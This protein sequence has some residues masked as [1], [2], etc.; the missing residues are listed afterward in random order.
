MSLSSHSF[1]WNT[2]QSFEGY[3]RV[4]T[5]VKPSFIL[6][7]IFNTGG[8]SGSQTSM[9]LTCVGND[10]KLNYGG[11]QVYK[12]G[13]KSDDPNFWTKVKVTFDHGTIKIYV[14]NKLVDTVQAT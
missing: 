11:T 8:S 5:Y 3:F 14:D 4:P 12:H 2:Q 6:T 1:G 7:Q 10:L 9:H 13:I